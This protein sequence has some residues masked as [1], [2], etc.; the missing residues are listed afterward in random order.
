MLF[1][2]RVT[3]ELSVWCCSLG[4]EIESKVLR[5]FFYRFWPKERI[6]VETGLCS[7]FEGFER[8]KKALLVSRWWIIEFCFWF[9]F[10][11]FSKDMTSLGIFFET[12]ISENFSIDHWA[13]SCVIFWSEKI[14][15]KFSG[16]M[17]FLYKNFRL[18]FFIQ[19]RFVFFFA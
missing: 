6:S 8:S 5:I 13:W 10:D 17:G 16:K 15:E 2:K 14:K 12:P 7:V 9:F 3:L 1:L 11:I 19:V 18:S 4:A